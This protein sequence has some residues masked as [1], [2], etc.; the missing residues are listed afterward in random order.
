MNPEAVTIDGETRDCADRF[1]C[2]RCGPPVFVRTADEIEV[3]VGSLDAIDH[4]A[5]TYENWAVR[6]ESW[7]PPFPLSKC[8]DRD[9]EATSR[10]EE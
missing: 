7:L 4:L 1:F 8:C 6:R 2:P 3:S 10:F 9:R 5:P